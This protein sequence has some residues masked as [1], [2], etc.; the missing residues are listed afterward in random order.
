MLMIPTPERA[1]ALLAA[2]DP[3]GEIDGIQ[4]VRPEVQ[5]PQYDPNSQ[6]KAQR[7]VPPKRRDKS[8]RKPLD[9]EHQVDDYA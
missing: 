1:A 2:T 8:P 6:S 4:P 3:M 9:P 5:R 7:R